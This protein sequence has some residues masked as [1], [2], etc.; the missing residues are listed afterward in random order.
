MDKIATPRL[1]ILR[2]SVL[3][4]A[5]AIARGVREALDTASPRGKVARKEQPR[6]GNL[7]KRLFVLAALFSLAACASSQP[8]TFAGQFDPPPASSRILVMTPDVQLSVL[9]AAGISEPREDWS[10]SGRDNLAAGLASY[11]Q[12]ENHSASALD[13]STAM[14]GRIGQII[15]LHDAVGGSIR[16]IHYGFANIPTRENDFSWTLGE[17]V[18]ELASAYN[19]DYALF[20]VARGTYSSGARMALAVLAL[21][22]TGAGQQALASL[23][24]L[25]TGNII[26]FNV[27]LAAPGEDMRNAEGATGLIRRLMQDAP[28]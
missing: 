9:G 16:D 4:Q 19:A 5:P 15:R 11:I 8:R 12:G 20:V 7:V 24:D 26:W 27:A 14:E 6:E 22:P 17:G 18:R 2:R 21:S 25:R 23:V 1:I 13:P 10:V 3:T 28:L